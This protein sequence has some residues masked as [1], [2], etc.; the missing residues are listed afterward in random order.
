MSEQS[1]KPDGNSGTTKSN[2]AYFP[3]FK[4]SDCKCE[5]L[6]CMECFHTAAV[7]NPLVSLIH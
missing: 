4:C 1:L 7:T 2:N 6:H 3:L 5:E